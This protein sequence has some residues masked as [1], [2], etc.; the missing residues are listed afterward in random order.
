MIQP[1]DTYRETQFRPQAAK[2]LR[3]T[4]IR[5]IQREFPR[6]G[7]PWVV[8]LFVDKLLQLVDTYRITRDRLKPGQT[9][10][11]TVAIDERTGYRKPMAETRQ[12]PVVIT[13]AAVGSNAA[14][15]C[16]VAWCGPP[17]TLMPKAGWYPSPIW[18]CSSTTA[19]AGSPS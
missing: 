13:V 7:G 2:T 15:S 12:V 1:R 4:L 10:W 11:Q 9:L 14:T 16:S 19:K 18:L 3:Q 17:T 8:E 6:L 5:F